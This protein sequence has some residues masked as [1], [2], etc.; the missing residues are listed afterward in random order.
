MYVCSV[1]YGSLLLL[2]LLLLLHAAFILYQK[3]T[4][5][6][7]LITFEAP[8]LMRI[9]NSTESSP[10]DRT[11]FNSSVSVSYLSLLLSPLY[12][13]YLQ[14]QVSFIC[15]TSSESC[16]WVICSRK[17]ERSLYLQGQP[18]QV[19]LG[20]LTMKIRAVRFFETFNVMRFC[21]QG[22]DSVF[23]RNVGAHLMHYTVL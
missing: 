23:L 11:H 1:K 8:H 6:A 20:H 4:W 7:L 3:W 10:L 19:L 15:R 18:I 17:F 12:I 16:Y 14:G 22:G 5:W 2:L 13:N 9:P 21:R